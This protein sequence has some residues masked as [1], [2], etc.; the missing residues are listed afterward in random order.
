M[1]KRIIMVGLLIVVVLN[2]MAWLIPGLCDWYTLHVTPILV[3]T[4]GRFSGLFKFSLGEIL[5]Y[6]GIVILIASV[7]IGIVLIFLHK[8]SAFKKFSIVY[9][10][11]V[12]YILVLVCLIMTLNCSMLYHCT[13]LDPNPEVA[14][15]EYSVYELQI[16]RNYIVEKCNEYSINMDRDEQGHMI[17]DKDMQEQA[18]NALRNLSDRYPKLSGYYPDVKELKS[19]NLMSQAYMAGYYFPFSMEA[20]CNANMYISNFPEVYCHELSHL[21]GYIYEDEANFI[22][23]LACISCEDDFFEYCGYLGVLNY[24]DNAYFES[25]GGDVDT[26]LTQT[27]ISQQVYDDNVFLLEET[28]E[29]VEAVAVFSTDRVDAV[30]DAFTETS[31]QLNGVKEGMAS[32]SAVVDLLL[33]FYDGILY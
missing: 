10:K 33:Q 15:R 25:I 30:T 31:L 29:E 1:Y 28:W 4:F 12:S 17:Y 7:I 2:M 9:Y 13:R 19:S 22:S 27:L 24:V 20:N 23:Y 18:K 16:L 11:I 26:Y 8:K 6:I 5:I 3:N 21:H 14:Y 32:Y